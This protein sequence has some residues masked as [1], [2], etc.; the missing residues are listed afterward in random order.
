LL[1]LSSLLCCDG[2]FCFGGCGV[3]L[4]VVQAGEPPL[5]HNDVLAGLTGHESYCGSRTQRC[6]LCSANVA[7]KRALFHNIAVHGTSSASM[8]APAP[9]DGAS[10]PAL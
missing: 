5:D 6:P 2:A 3:T 8:G 9:I 7:L 10:S 1:L 4:V